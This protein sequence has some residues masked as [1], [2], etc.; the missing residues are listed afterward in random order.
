[1]SWISEKYRNVILMTAPIIITG[2]AL[3]Y[4][5]YNRSKILVQNQN[6]NQNQNQSKPV[7]LQQAVT[8]F[9]QN[10]P[11]KSL[12]NAELVAGVAPG[13]VN[14]IGEHTDYN[15]GFVF[16]MAIN[17]QTVV[18]GRFNGL[19][20]FR[21][22]S[23]NISDE[24]VVELDLEQMTKKTVQR[25]WHNYLRGVVYQYIAAGYTIKPFDCIVL[26]T[27]PLGGGLSSSASLEVAVATF[28]DGLLKIK[29][30]QRDMALLCQEAEHQFAHV[31]CG[32]MDQFISVFGQTDHA[33]LLDCRSLESTLVKLSDPKISLLI[34]NSN[35]KHELS[36][37][38]YSERRRQCEQAVAALKTIRSGIKA[39]RDT[40]MEEL[41]KA[42]PSIDV[43]IYRRA[44]HVITEI[45][46]TVRARQCLE[47]EKYSEFGRLMK[48]SH[49]SLQQDFQ[50][51]CEEL[52]ILVEIANT[53]RG[54]YGSRMTGGG[55]GGCTVTLVQ[56][57]E[58]EKVA[59]TIKKGYFERTNKEATCMISRPC[60]GATFYRL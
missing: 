7:I 10:F 53:C 44:R 20:K 16:P 52:D 8:L 46:R 6:Q 24:K 41:E 30:P 49:V 27:I 4:Y 18:V 19:E 35:V 31:P 21:L 9:H 5:M 13:R 56:T 37:G 32:V 26:G 1:M 54:V 57:S 51:S 33:L 42:R 28:L 48:E 39:L 29:T 45:Q 55:F 15:D 40:D 60:Q 14:L 47:K 34:T 12:S 2:A 43:T 22:F 58:A 36:S 3:T 59:A 23:A 17:Q 50:V 38:E 25:A 11:S